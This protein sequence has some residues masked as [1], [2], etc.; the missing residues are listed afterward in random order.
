MGE[1]ILIKET[2]R[3]WINKSDDYEYIDFSVFL[4]RSNELI[5]E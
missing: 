2:N 4:I 5:P 1:S 3:F